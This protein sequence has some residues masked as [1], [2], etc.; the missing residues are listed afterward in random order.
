MNFDQ[1]VFLSF[2]LVFL[3]LYLLLYLYLQILKFISLSKLWFF[4]GILDSHYLELFDQL[5]SYFYL[6]Q[7]S[8]LSLRTIP[9]TFLRE[10]RGLDQCIPFL[11]LNNMI[12]SS[13]S[14]F[15]FLQAFYHFHFIYQSFLIPRSRQIKILPRKCLNI[16]IHLSLVFCNLYLEHFFIT[17]L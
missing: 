17:P 14:L 4:M 6:R 3:A 16:R 7:H 8:S 13:V 1:N 2:T 12:H 15:F 9:Y 5:I 11:H 10:V